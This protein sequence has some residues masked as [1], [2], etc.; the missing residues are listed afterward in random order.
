MRPKEWSPAWYRALIRNARAD[1]GRLEQKSGRSSGIRLPDGDQVPLLRLIAE[2]LPDAGPPRCPRDD[3]EAALW[4]NPTAYIH[5]TLG[6]DRDE[7]ELIFI[8]RRRP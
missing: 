5:N 3:A 4:A 8:G 6:R 1:S 2:Y 7:Q